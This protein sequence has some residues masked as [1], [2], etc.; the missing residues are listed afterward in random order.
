[1]NE[2]LHPILP[3]IDTLHLYLISPIVCLSNVNDG[4]NYKITTHDIRK[5][6]QSECKNEND[7]LVEQ[8]DK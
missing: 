7:N 4:N 6:K 8:Y 5:G 3:K 1:M 2:F